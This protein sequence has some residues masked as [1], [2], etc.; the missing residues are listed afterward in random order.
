MSRDSPG[1]RH[2]IWQF[3]L[4]QLIHKLLIC[5][6]TFL[7][8]VQRCLLF[9]SSFGE[10]CF[11][12]EKCFSRPTSRP[13]SHSWK[14]ALK[15]IFDHVNTFCPPI[16]PI[17]TVNFLIG[18]MAVTSVDPDTG[19]RGRTAWQLEQLWQ[20]NSCWIREAV[21]CSC[22]NLERTRSGSNYKQL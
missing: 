12:K 1:S 9:D 15:T 18:Q 3:V 5:K 11:K 22:F 19:L 21:A 8:L 2:L 6:K 14:A 20:R 7:N 4:C 17:L 10:L 16:S 13:G